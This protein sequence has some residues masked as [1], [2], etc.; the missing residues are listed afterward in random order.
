MPKQFAD[1]YKLFQAGGALLPE[2]VTVKS[3]VLMG[4]SET[5]RPKDFTRAWTKCTAAFRQTR[6][7][8]TLALSCR[9]A[10]PTSGRARGHYFAY[11]PEKVTDQ[12]PAIVFLH[13]FGGNFLFYTYL[14]K[15]EFPKAVVLVPSWGASW[16][17]GTMQYLDDMYKDVKRRK[18][19]SV[20]KPC[21]MAISAG[22]PA[23]FRLYNAKPDRFA[24]YVSLASAPALKI[25]PEL[26]DNLKILMINGKQDSGFKVT[27]V[28]SLASK[29][30][31]RL[32]HFQLHVVDGD[33]FFLLSKREET[34][35]II[36]KFVEKEANWP[37][38]EAHP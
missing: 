24:C 10:C 17:D 31:E 27:Y 20:R 2:Q 33:H 23:G 13:G 18:S 3:V 1:G 32:P 9:T 11:Y 5:G 8:R 38:N 37:S 19:F 12:T 4:R 26:K 28:E 6:S 25:V 16:G 15:E 36:K 22:G 14:L 35:R 30:A 21:L 34:F 29:M 7:S